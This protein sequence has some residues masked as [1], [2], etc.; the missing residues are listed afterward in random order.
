MESEDPEIIQLEL[1]YCERLCAPFA[2]GA[3]RVLRVLRCGNHGTAGTLAGGETPARQ[4]SIR[5]KI[6]ASG[7]QRNLHRSW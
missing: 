2:W 4:S 1:K 5:H 6:P 7:G 3:G